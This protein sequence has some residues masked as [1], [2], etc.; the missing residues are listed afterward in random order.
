MVRMFDA[1][2]GK[3]RKYGRE[4]PE[5]AAPGDAIALPDVVEKPVSPAFVP[6]WKPEFAKRKLTKQIFNRLARLWER[7][8]P[9][10]CDDDWVCACV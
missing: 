4:E 8:V 7:L 6:A 5:C 2:F 3:I 9:P 1:L 10:S